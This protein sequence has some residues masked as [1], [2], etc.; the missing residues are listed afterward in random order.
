MAVGVYLFRDLAITILFTEKFR[1][2]RELFAIQLVGD[3]LKI[4]SWLYAY[5][6]ISRGATKWFV[7]SEVFFAGSLVLLT[8]ALVPHFETNGANI[9]Y[10]INYIIYLVFVFFAMKY[11]IRDKKDSYEST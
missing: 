4:T 11:I 1:A 7:S 5:P 8:S 10:A 2:A 3:V 6:M 9:A